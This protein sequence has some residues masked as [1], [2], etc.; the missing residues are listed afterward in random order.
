MAS[1]SLR[2]DGEQG[3][4]I[5][6]EG[7]GLVAFSSTLSAIGGA[8]G[9]K[10]SVTGDQVHLQNA[11]VDASGGIRGG[12]VHLGGGWQGGGDLPHSR[13]VLIGAGSEVKANGGDGMSN[14]N[15]KG[16]EIAVWS[17]QSSHNYGTLQ[18]LDGGRIE[19]S[20]RADTSSRGSTSWAGRRGVIRSQK[21]YHH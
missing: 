17:T 13:Q 7:S 20:S 6:V 3:G 19:L 5:Q 16:G 14:P 4:N 2:A 11:D 10:I 1:G 8:S 18:A 15:A 21:Y 12:I 9:G